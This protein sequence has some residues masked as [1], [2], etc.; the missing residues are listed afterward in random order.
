MYRFFVLPE[1]IQGST[2]R[3]LGNDVKHIKDVLRLKSGEKIHVLDGMGNRYIVVI[4]EVSHQA[5]SGEIFSKEKYEIESHLKVHM[6]QALIKGSKID[7]IIKKSVELGVSSIYGLKTER[8]IAKIKEEDV[9]GKIARW[10]KIVMEACKQCG[11][12]ISPMVEK[13]ILTVE[14][15]CEKHTA[16]DLK[17]IFWE[18]EEITRLKDVE[19]PKK[20]SSVAFIAGPEG[21]FLPGEVEIARKHGFQTVSLG[22][23]IIRAETA[24]PV[25]NGLLQNMWGDL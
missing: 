18:N 9:E 22:P 7:G 23:R 17:L 15:F 21:G 6:G 12:N 2:I 8:C 16:C 24:S 25:I 13:T 20:I 1:N 3:L 4:S 19:V 11:R 14:G 5:V 10:N